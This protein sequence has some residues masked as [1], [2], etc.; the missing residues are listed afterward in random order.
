MLPTHVERREEGEEEGEKEETPVPVPAPLPPFVSVAP[1]IL[2]EAS[3]SGSEL[4]PVIHHSPL[5]TEM[6]AI[7]RSDD[8]G[9]DTPIPSLP[10]AH[11][12]S[13]P[14][15]FALA[16][17]ER[18]RVERFEDMEKQLVETVQGAEEG[19]QRREDMFRHNEDER[20]RMFLEREERRTAEA[21]AREEELL[22]EFERRL[23]A[24]MPPPLPVPPP[25]G[26]VDEE[27]EAPSPEPT[28]EV[29]EVPVSEHEPT[30]ESAA[31]SRAPSM[32]APSIVDVD[33]ERRT[34][35]EATSRYSQELR[36]II[37]AEREDARR[38]LDA[39]RTEREHREEELAS[40]RQ[41]VE[42]EHQT[43]IRLLQEQIAALQA[44]K[45]ERE[46][47]E[48]EEAQRH[49]NERN[50]D[51]ERAE[52]QA[53]Q[54]AE[55]TNLVSEQREESIRKR[56]LQ[57]QR[58][59]EKQQRRLMKDDM[60]NGLQDMIRQLIQEK[61]ECKVREDERMHQLMSAM[62]G[63]SPLLSSI[64]RRHLISV[65]LV[66]QA[67]TL[68]A[69]SSLKNEI[70]DSLRQM[71]DGKYSLCSPRTVTDARYRMS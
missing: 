65:I 1:S 6:H 20:E 45:D 55:I 10:P 50:E 21:K 28:L 2:R 58:W 61:E 66:M 33:A 38:Q 44:E 48:L 3:P 36:E 57:D 64:R 69:M 40:E 22:L 56:D 9:H 68:D 27:E 67:Q 11:A 47:R 32:R 53:A 60:F 54:L 24:I 39:E 15:D 51:N 7:P 35:V 4:S 5:A 70:S 16:D 17:A 41:R 30:V 31:P 37:D 13:G 14:D 59:E 42:E 71:A 8:P 34:L 43:H 26:G 52:Q 12:P 49:E 19:E 25:P 18:E 46:A 63:T 62:Q 23:E 29:A